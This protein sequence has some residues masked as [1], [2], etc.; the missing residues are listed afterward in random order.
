MTVRVALLPVFLS[1][2]FAATDPLYK[3]MREAAIAD[4][5][6]VE[7]IVIKRDG[8][9]LTLKTGAIGFTAPAMG[10]DTIAVFAG[11]GEFTFTAQSPIDH[12][13]MKS[14]TGQD[15][16]SEQFD[17]A[18]L[19]FTDDTGKEIRA[20]AK[21]PSPDP[22]LA[23]ILR[24]YRKHLRSRLESPRSMIEAMVTDEVMDNLE[25]DLLTDLYNPHAQ[26]FF[27]AYLHG[28]KHSDL[29]F[30]V[31]PRGALPALSDTP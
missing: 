28:R 6:V 2:A 4:T 24:D 1:A 13:Y 11:E 18:L 20:S 23:E 31:R 16:I 22:K 5:F 26:G 19:S 29:R 15:V 14:L 21:T 12:A 27:N 9:V 30:R 17:H 7:N 8:G 10:R 25:A 3:S